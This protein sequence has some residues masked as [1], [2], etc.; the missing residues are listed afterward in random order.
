MSTFKAVITGAVLGAVVVMAAWR[1]DASGALAGNT[2]DDRAWA[3]P[4]F[5]YF[6]FGSD[7]AETVFVTGTLI[8]K[9]VGY[10]NNTW[11]I[12]C[13]RSDN[14][15]RT[16]SVEEIGRDQLGQINLVEWPVVTWTGST[17]VARSDPD[18][19]SS[20]G[21]Q[22][23]TINRDAKSVDYVAIPQNL[24]RDYCKHF[25][26]DPKTYH[27]SIGQAP[28]PWKKEATQGVD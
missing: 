28:K 10:K 15:C 11:E 6:V 22:T 2:I 9:G 20:C 12:R 17:I 14:V 13:V 26:H 1:I 5:N 7:E 27:W 18:D 3:L 21:R 4:D 25:F 16:A 8:G 19:T 23:L 24:D